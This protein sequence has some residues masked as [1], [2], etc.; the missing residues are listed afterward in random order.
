MTGLRVRKENKPTKLRLPEPNYLYEWK[1]SLEGS[2]EVLQKGG[3]SQKKK[4]KPNQEESE[5]QDG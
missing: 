5:T 1:N 2:E 4:K 3:N